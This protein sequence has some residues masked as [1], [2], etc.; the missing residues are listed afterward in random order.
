MPTEKTW[1]KAYGKAISDETTLLGRNKVSELVYENGEAKREEGKCDI[2]DCGE[3]VLVKLKSVFNEPLGG[4]DLGSF[5]QALT[6]WI[7]PLRKV[8]RFDVD[9]KELV[10]AGAT[11]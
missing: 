11:W 7:V 1:S 5:E 3:H 10:E 4:K 8:T 9:L 2:K 6:L